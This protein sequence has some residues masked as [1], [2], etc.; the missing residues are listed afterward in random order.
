M[1][2]LRATGI[3]DSQRFCQKQRC[4]T[5]PTAELSNMTWYRD[6]ASQQ[7]HDGQIPGKIDGSYIKRPVIYDRPKIGWRAV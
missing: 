7:V 2:N 4:R 3:E 1:D 5:S 6:C